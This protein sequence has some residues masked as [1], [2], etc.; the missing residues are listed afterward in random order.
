LLLGE[1]Y[2]HLMLNTRERA[3]KRDL[4]S[5]IH[6]RQIQTAVA[7]HRALL[8]Q[9]DLMQAHYR[10][11]ELYR[12]MGYVDLALQQLRHSLRRSPMY[13]SGPR[14]DHMDQAIEA[15][16]TEV[17]KRQDRFANQ[18]ALASV[19]ERAIR[20]IDNGLAGKALDILLASD[21]A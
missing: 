15:L 11:Y 20:A 4:P 6:V 14:E 12:D 8:I 13:G 5:L 16:D 19:L 7:L 1:A 18:A 3:W 17:R 10:L 9:P 21:V 2:L